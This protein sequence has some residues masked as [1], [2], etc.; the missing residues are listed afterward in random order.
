MFITSPEANYRNKETGRVRY[1]SLLGYKKDISR[2]CMIRRSLYFHSILVFLLLLPIGLG[3]AG[4]GYLRVISAMGLIYFFIR[5][6]LDIKWSTTIFLFLFFL[7]PETWAFEF[8]PSLPLITLRRMFYV[9]LLISY[10]LRIKKLKNQGQ[11]QNSFRFSA[12]FLILSYA[13]STIFSVDLKSSLFGLLSLVIEQMFLMLIIFK[14]FCDKS[15]A[16]LGLTAILISL[17][18][19][20]FFAN[21][22]L[23][24]KTNHFTDVSLGSVSPRVYWSLYEQS[25]RLG[26]Y[27]RVQ[28]LFPHPMSFGG[29]LAMCFPIIVGFLLTEKKILMRLWLSLFLVLCVEGVLIS[30]ARSSVIT[31]VSGII[32]MLILMFINDRTDMAIYIIFLTI[33]LF[34]VVLLYEPS[35]Q[36]LYSSLKFWEQP[37]YIEGSSLNGRISLVKNSIY[38]IKFKPLIGYGTAAGANFIMSINFAPE[39]FGGIENFWVRVILDNGIIGLLAM[40]LFLLHGLMMLWKANSTNRNRDESYLSAAGI[41]SFISFLVFATATGTLGLF[42]FVFILL[43]LII[44]Y[45]YDKK[46]INKIQSEF[47]GQEC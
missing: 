30:L 11:F 32:V 16:K 45:C 34:I 40:I 14:V 46:R 29:F 13:I 47:S 24:S 3:F 2:I 7:L 27:G 4:S 10:L 25:E 20:C 6:I 39:I 15:L 19:L 1:T 36:M 18:I 12:Y 22:Q 5:S 35:R 23:L 37:D 41:S 44:R 33:S 43:P 26:Q 9:S 8:G 21:V 42:N 31:L 38:Y 17:L 28:S